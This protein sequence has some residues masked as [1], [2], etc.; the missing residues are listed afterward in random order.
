MRI[1]QK[2][3]MTSGILFLIFLALLAPA[4]A[5]TLCSYNGPDLSDD[6]M[7]L[8]NFTVAGPDS[9]GEGD[10]ITI[11]F[12]IT[13][14]G[15]NSINLTEKG[16]YAAVRDKDD[17]NNDFGFTNGNRT[18]EP[19]DSVHFEDI[20]EISE[21][22][23]LDIWPSY[24]FWKSA[25][26]QPLKKYV[27]IR[28]DGPDFWQGCEL[29]ICPEYCENKVRYYDPYVGQDNFCVYKEEK[30]SD[31]CNGTECMKM[32]ADTTPPYVNVSYSPINAN[33]TSNITFMATARD[34]SNIT[35]IIIYVNGINVKECSASGLSIKKDSYG[36]IWICN[37]DGR[38][39]SAGTATYKAEAF[40]SF[41]NKGSS[42]T[43]ILSVA[44]ISFST[45]P[46]NV[47]ARVKY[48]Y[49][50]AGKVY[51]FPDSFNK[52]FVK[53]SICPAE[54]KCYDDVMGRNK[55]DYGC[56]ANASMTYAN[57]TKPLAST[58]LEYNITLP[59]GMYIVKPVYQPIGNCGIRI[60]EPEKQFVDI[61]ENS[62]TNVSFNYVQI[63][64]QEPKVDVLIVA[65]KGLG[66][67]A[68]TEAYSDDE[69]KRLESKIVEYQNVLAEEGL[70]S[71]FVYIDSTE[72][73][74]L[75][76]STVNYGNEWEIRGMVQELGQRLN[77]SYLLIIGGDNRQGIV[78]EDINDNLYGD[79]NGDQIMDMAVGRIP[80]PVNGDIN[81]L[82]NYLDTAIK[83]HR[84]GGLD[85]S[86]YQTL[87]M[88]LPW[89]MGSCFHNSVYNKTCNSDPR[90]CKMDND[91]SFVEANG[92][93]F[94]TLLL[95]GDRETTQ[96]VSCNR[97][98]E[99]STRVPCAVTKCVGW[100]NGKGFI[101]VE[102]SRLNVT[103]SFWL[104]ATCS[105]SFIYNKESTEQ[106]IPMTFLKQGGAIYIGAINLMYGGLGCPSE[107]GNCKACVDSSCT[108]CTEE[109]LGGDAC[110][111][112]M[113][114][115]IAKRF[116]S[117][118]R[119][120]DAYKE[121]MNYYLQNYNCAYGTRYHYDI[122]RIY[123]DPTLKIKNMW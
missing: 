80:D 113:Y 36:D 28:T 121:G 78:P 101:A 9:P 41:D 17:N 94:F 89:N 19:L 53:V 31:G 102:L 88:S 49:T 33:I 70:C 24:E 112:S 97:Q 37:Y 61:T 68:L 95:H 79:I 45:P 44:N 23:L 14:F 74:A 103:D 60:F 118:E 86:N 81:L 119:I 15:Q 72:A 22:G 55:C 8:T 93:G 117:G 1:G 87:A 58:N 21:K 18:L 59:A 92:K 43:K 106:S 20:F 3:L 99:C 73:R 46:E 64:A 104:T 39:Y 108:Q 16:V 62:S 115:E 82:L 29:E 123:G 76:G 96:K 111:S 38:N 90:H 75:T 83:L 110:S 57:V 84:S 105:G 91:C 4:E 114:A 35:R 56:A 66:H 51:N 26:S 65:A 27:T 85:L 42:G 32:I 12:D 100:S 5:A 107:S 7:Q 10:K 50:I 122:T 109:I 77:P 47:T 6:M 69:I 40:D 98:C 67:S 48:L 2:F 25:Y 13:N 54:K 30:C 52:D 71:V 116:A 63:G 11:K 34:I 120:G